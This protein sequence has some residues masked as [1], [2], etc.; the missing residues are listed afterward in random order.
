MTTP[1]RLGPGHRQAALPPL[2]AILLAVGACVAP[3]G[4]S[5]VPASPTSPAPTAIPSPSAATPTGISHPSGARDVVFR[6][7]Q[8]GG[9]IAPDMAFRDMPALSV[10]GDGL[11]IVDGPVIAIYPGPALRNLQA[12]H[13]SE[14]GLQRLLAEARDAG[15]L[16]PD[17]AWDAVGVAD[18]S[19]AI[20]TTVA[21]GATHTVSAYGLTEAATD[22]GLDRTTAAARGTL[23]A[24]VERLGDLAGLVGSDQL[25]AP[26]SYRPGAV[27]LRIVEETPDAP[28]PSPAQSPVAWPLAP[29]LALFGAPVGGPTGGARCGV[30]AGADL[31]AL[32]PLLEGATPLTPWTSA[33]RR[34]LLVIRQLLPDESGCPE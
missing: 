4:G 8:V 1:I 29:S 20:F 26:G 30:V 34:Y 32:Y 31:D 10:F 33:G 23:R 27:R 16:G 6:Y 25:T 12:S 15:L 19:T 11:V 3:G 28:L 18:G 9:F 13:I 21:G 2:L 22:A 17:A 24:F 7:S 5:A 14:T